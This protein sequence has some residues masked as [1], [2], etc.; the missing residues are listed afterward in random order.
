MLVTG[1][2]SGKQSLIAEV[3]HRTV[4]L[5]RGGLFGG[6]ARFEGWRSRKRSGQR[7]QRAG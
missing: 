7:A 5:T 4:L 2:P 1:G 6:A 3:P